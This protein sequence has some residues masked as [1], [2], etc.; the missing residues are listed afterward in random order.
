MVIDNL[1]IDWT[2]S[3]VGPLKADPP[4]VVNMDA[5]L[6]LP[7]AFQRFKPVAGKSGEIF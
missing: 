2:G 7:I 5:I 6:A 4:S 3:A 1:D